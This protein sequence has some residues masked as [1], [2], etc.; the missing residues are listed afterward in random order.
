MTLITTNVSHLDNFYQIRQIPTG[1]SPERQ[2]YE[3]LTLQRR[4]CSSSGH[5]TCLWMGAQGDSCRLPTEAW[6]KFSDYLSLSYLSDDQTGK[7]RLK[8]RLSNRRV[9]RT[10]PSTEANTPKQRVGRLKSTPLPCATPASGIGS[11][12]PSEPAH[13]CRSTPRRLSRQGDSS[14]F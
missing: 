9:P 10:Q 8:H 1:K 14:T 4:S 3:Q 7:Q 2:N 11:T 6:R 5:T 13:S 12:Q